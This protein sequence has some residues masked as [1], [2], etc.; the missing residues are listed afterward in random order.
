MLDNLYERG[1]TPTLIHRSE[2]INKLMDNDMNEPIIESLKERNITYH[3][4]E[5]IDTIK[6]KTV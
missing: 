2:H 3:F 5:E 4:N 6:G 1:I